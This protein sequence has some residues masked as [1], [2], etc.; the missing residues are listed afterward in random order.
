[1]KNENLY[2]TIFNM[3]WLEDIDKINKQHNEKGVRPKLEPWHKRAQ[4]PTNI[5]MRKYPGQNGASTTTPLYALLRI[6]NRVKTK[7]AYFVQDYW[8]QLFFLF[9]DVFDFFD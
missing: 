5:K 2:E 8:K 7:D 4:N 9:F 6:K 1:M 3:K